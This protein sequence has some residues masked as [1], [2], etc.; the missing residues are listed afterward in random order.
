MIVVV[1]ADIPVTTPVE[2]TVATE[3]LLL[4]HVPPAVVSESVIVV[5]T[6]VEEAPMIGPMAVVDAVTVN[7]IVL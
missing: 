4:L 2:L 7:V 5:P 3:G 6:Q 1:P